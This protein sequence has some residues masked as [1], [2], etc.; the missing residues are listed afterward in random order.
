MTIVAGASGETSFSGATTVWI[1]GIQEWLAASPRSMGME[2]TITVVCV[3]AASM[4]RKQ[5]ESGWFTKGKIKKLDEM[6]TTSGPAVK[7]ANFHKPLVQVFD[8][9]AMELGA[10]FWNQHGAEILGRLS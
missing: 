7:D 4:A 1:K 8:F 3:F 2:G 9:L 5:W 10:D 6:I